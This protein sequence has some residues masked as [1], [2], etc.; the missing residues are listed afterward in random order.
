MFSKNSKSSHYNP[1]NVIVK[2]I[3]SVLVGVG[4]F[5]A[6]YA[7]LSCEWFIF[8][9]PQEASNDVTNDDNN[10]S[11]VA[12]FTEK[13][14]THENATEKLTDRG[15]SSPFIPSNIDHTT[16]QSVGL[17]RYQSSSTTTENFVTEPK[18]DDDDDDDERRIQE[19][20]LLH[21]CVR[22]EPLFRLEMT[23]VFVSQI[24][25]LSGPVIAFLAWLVAMLGVNKYPAALLLFL[26]TG[27][28]ATSV[29]FSM[30]LCENFWDC[31]WLL[32]SL[33]DVVATGL[34]FL[35]WLAAMCGLVVRKNRKNL[36]A[37]GNNLDKGSKSFP[38]LQIET[39]LTEDSEDSNYDDNNS[40]RSG[41]FCGMMVGDDEES[42]IPGVGGGDDSSSSSF[43]VLGGELSSKNNNQRRLS[44]SRPR[45]VSMA[46]SSRPGSV[47]D[48]ITRINNTRAQAQAQTK[49][50]TPTTAA[51][52]KEDMTNSRMMLSE[53]DVIS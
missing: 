6:L 51:H 12:K 29:I 24:C 42:Q 16:V 8:D 1:R 27:V 19:E 46:H 23:W 39:K 41:P 32:G 50:N 43:I 52:H 26:A 38:E 49:T 3:I 33:A 7:T 35:S 10:N 45:P 2:S 14:P 17:F 36:E 5:L 53:E 18:L 13:T 9:I 4:I 40:Y 20:S 44:L 28:Q 48:M 22:Y 34:F 47:R 11:P 25:V 21:H 30:S 37:D 15:S 31:P